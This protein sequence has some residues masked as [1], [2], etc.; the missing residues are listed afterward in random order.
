MSKN[1]TTDTSAEAPKHTPEI[2]WKD[3]TSASEANSVRIIE[4][5][6]RKIDTVK[7]FSG[8]YVVAKCYGPDRETNARL[9]AAAPELLAALMAAKRQIDAFLSACDAKEI[10]DSFSGMDEASDRARAAIAQAEGRT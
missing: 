1:Q 7:F 8:D 2:V 9:I 10:K 3:T 6:P 5:I 4:A